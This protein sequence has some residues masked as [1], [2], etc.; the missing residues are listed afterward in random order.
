LGAI[1]SFA[2]ALVRWPTEILGR[3][4]LRWAKAG[5]AATDPLRRWLTDRLQVHRRLYWVMRWS[6]TRRWSIL[7]RGLPAL[8]A[9]VG[10]VV[11]AVMVARHSPG[12]RT[13]GYE[14]EAQLAWQ[15]DDFE[16]AKLCLRRLALLNPAEPL[17]IY[18]L[19]HCEARLGNASRTWA[20]ME[21]IAGT[22]RPG[23]APA[24]MWQAQQLMRRGHLSAEQLQAAER[25]LLCCL[26]VQPQS[27][28]AD[29]LLG[30]LYLARGQSDQAEIH[31]QRVNAYG[32]PLLLLARLHSD[33]GKRGMAR[34]EAA[35]ALRF[36][37]GRAEA[38]PKNVAFRLH[39][40]EAA[41]LLDQYPM[42]VQILETG[43]KDS[44]VAAYRLALAR[45]YDRWAATPAM[46]GAA[47][48]GVRL[49][50]VQQALRH[51]HGNPDALKRFLTLC[52]C[53]TPETAPT[54][55]ELRR[56]LAADPNSVGLQFIVAMHFHACGEPEQARR[57]FAA[58][59]RLDGSFAPILNN[60]A[61]IHSHSEATD[62]A[63]SLP[64]IEAALQLD[65]A[66]A[67]YRD[68]RGHVHARLGRWPDAVADLE[69]ATVLLPQ[70]AERN[71]LLAEARRH[72]GGD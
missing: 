30:Q 21:S 28:E 63:R 48:F 72:L 44:S 5:A 23:Y 64:L 62:P 14:R 35:V 10:A 43:W 41:M 9:V 46:Q 55:E 61:W 47:Q 31:L 60:L 37:Q 67:H 56:R 6:V 68:T 39:W 40:A 12:R 71:E 8:T 33:Q 17:H 34:A 29:A 22:D 20:L 4:E 24:H 15:R 38:E 58:A 13:L 65:P 70:S 36:F 27:P 19:A 49:L 59:L 69:V 54:W 1:D 26:E 7:L 50:L 57:H 32:E 25:H 11:V 51:D 3:A 2:H 66:N 16:R 45:T 53:Q 52:Q 18:R 42:A